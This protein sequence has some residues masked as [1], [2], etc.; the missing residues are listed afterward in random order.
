MLKNMNWLVKFL[1]I[2]FT[3]IERYITLS[4]AMKVVLTIFMATFGVAIVPVLFVMFG[5]NYLV[6]F[7]GWKYLKIGFYGAFVLLLLFKFAWRNVKKKNKTPKETKTRPP[8]FP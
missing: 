5:W 6:G 2:V 8:F 3:F 1:R 7:L 4:R